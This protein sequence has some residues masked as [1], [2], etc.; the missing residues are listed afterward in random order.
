MEADERFTVEVEPG[1]EWIEAGAASW[2]AGDGSSLSVRH[3]VRKLEGG[4]DPY[5]SG[6]IPIELLGRMVDVMRG[7][8][9][10]R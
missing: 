7:Y 6:E 4:F 3:Y 8:L 1:Q 5:S 2:D 10:H 9:Q